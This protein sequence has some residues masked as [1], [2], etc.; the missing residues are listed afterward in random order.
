MPNEIRSANQVSSLKV[1]ELLLAHAKATGVEC[2][3]LVL[4]KHDARELVSVD[5]ELEFVNDA[6]LFDDCFGC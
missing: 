3:V 2:A 6:D 5:Q 4:D 1:F